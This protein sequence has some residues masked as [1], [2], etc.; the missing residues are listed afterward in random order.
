[1]MI[2]SGAIIVGGTGIVALNR[3]YRQPS[4]GSKDATLPKEGTLPEDFIPAPLPKAGF[5]P[6]YPSPMRLPPPNL[7]LESRLHVDDPAPSFLTRCL[8]CLPQPIDLDYEFKRQSPVAPDASPTSVFTA[9]PGDS[10]EQLLPSVTTPV[11]SVALESHPPHDLAFSLLRITAHPGD[12]YEDLQAI[13][14]VNAFCDEALKLGTP[15][16]V[17]YDFEHGRLPPLLLGKQLL[18][19]CVKWAD[20]HARQWD[21]Q[22]QGLAVVI[23]NPVARAFL[24]TINRLLQ[25]PQPITY[26]ASKEE[27]M[28]F[29]GKI[30]VRRSYVKASY[31][32]H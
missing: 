29:L 9:F 5:I 28:S 12:F 6:A 4:D 11:V 17:L 30:R 3:W 26:V 8:G 15:L 10:I 16:L 20:D 7:P 27:A 31:K 32:S 22:V 24:N 13:P 1:M 25:P 18:S 21:D 14:N 19:L 2:Y 23:S